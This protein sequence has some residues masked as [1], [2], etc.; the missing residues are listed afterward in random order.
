MSLRGAYGAIAAPGEREVLIELADLERGAHLQQ[1]ID[2]D[3][4][5][6]PLGHYRVASGQLSYD[7]LVSGRNEI[8][9][10][11]FV[12]E[13]TSETARYSVAQ[14]PRVRQ[15]ADL[16]MASRA[17]EKTIMGLRTQQLSP[18]A[19]IAELQKTQMLL[20]N[21]GRTAEAQEVTQALRAIQ[22]G[23]KGTAEKT[24][25]GTMLNLD[26]GKHL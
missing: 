1:V 11:D 12:I 22:S 4:A 18:Q 14:D 19:A 5:N 26:Q 16:I 25:I 10:L 21:E 15:A 9:D 17:V 7:D 2:L 3:F 6:H 24:L 8:I 13:F 23:D 20:L